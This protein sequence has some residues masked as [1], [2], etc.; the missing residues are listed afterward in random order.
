MV[1]LDWRVVVKDMEMVH[2]KHEEG[3]QGTAK[4]DLDHLVPAYGAK[5]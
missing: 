2:A 1:R 4:P 5:L 3:G